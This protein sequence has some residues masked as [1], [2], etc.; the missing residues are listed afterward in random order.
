MELAKR[1]DLTSL[2][3]GLEEPAEEKEIRLK[4]TADNFRPDGEAVIACIKA[5]RDSRKDWMANT[6]YE[7]VKV[8]IRLMGGEGFFLARLSLHDPVLPINFESDV[9]G[10]VAAMAK[11]LYDVVKG[12]K[13]V[14]LTPLAELAR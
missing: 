14:D 11:Q 9:P 2:I 3:E 1:G 6:D 4:L 10:G 8:T 13:N 5:A 12:C 7:G